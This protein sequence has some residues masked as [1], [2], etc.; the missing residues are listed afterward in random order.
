MVKKGIHSV[1][2]LLLFPGTFQFFI[3]IFVC[4]SILGCRNLSVFNKVSGTLNKWA[5]KLLF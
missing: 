2:K 4:G 3:S 1:G 5:V